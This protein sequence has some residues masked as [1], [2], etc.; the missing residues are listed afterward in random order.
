MMSSVR[1][2]T[3]N[4]LHRD[5]AEY[6]A[7]AVERAGDRAL[8]LTPQPGD[9]EML[10]QWSDKNDP[11]CG[12]PSQRWHQRIVQYLKDTDSL[13]YV[14]R[15]AEHPNAATLAEIRCM[16]ALGK[17]VEDVGFFADPDVEKPW[18][19]RM[20]DDIWDI[21]QPGVGGNYFDPLLPSAP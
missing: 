16:G 20:A 8:V 12:I 5:Y 4:G 17:P 14:I 21:P 7:A 3:H 1:F 13:I 9:D 6:V 10:L 2:V 18:W 19:R 15:S 11:F